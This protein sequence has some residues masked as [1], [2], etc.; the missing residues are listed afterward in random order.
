MAEATG[1]ARTGSTAG[2]TDG[3]TTV[4]RTG[5][6][7]GMTAGSGTLAIVALP[8]VLT[9]SRLPPAGAFFYAFIF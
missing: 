5:S 1:G 2:S 4:A 7:D 3:T 9:L 8:L 6:T